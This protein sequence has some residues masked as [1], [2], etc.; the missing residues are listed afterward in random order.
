MK[1]ISLILTSIGILFLILGLSSMK[2]D[3]DLVSIYKTGF[4]FG[5]STSFVLIGVIGKLFFFKSK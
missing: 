5:I 3:M 1:K 2:S 4:L